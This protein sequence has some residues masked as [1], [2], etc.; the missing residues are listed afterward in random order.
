MHRNSGLLFE[1]YAK[2]LFK[3]QM[4]VLEIGPDGDPSTYRRIVADASLD[5]RTLDVDPTA[6]YTG[7]TKDQLSY[8]SP[9]EYRF[10]IEDNTFDIVLSGQVIE[11]VK[12]IWRWMPELARICKPGGLVITINP[13][14]WGYHEAP[15]D[16]WR[17][18]PEGIRALHEEAGLKTQLAVFESLDPQVE[19]SPLYLFKQAVKAL[20]GKKP[21]VPR[22]WLAAIDTVSIGQKP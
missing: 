1:K 18:Y 21:F 11:H 8:V 15:V 5:W 17:I 20:L 19:F 6:R 16:C 12:K 10:P 4:R 13:I 7:V 2:S 9:E 3:N 14:S 22:E